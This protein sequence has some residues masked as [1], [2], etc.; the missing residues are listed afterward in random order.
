MKIYSY[1]LNIAM[2]KFHAEE[3]MA[4]RAKDAKEHLSWDTLYILD[5]LLLIGMFTTK[6]PRVACDHVIRKKK[7]WVIEISVSLES[8]K[9]FSVT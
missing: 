1:S 8:V 5:F 7:C 4:V 6:E 3:K 2:F 9:T